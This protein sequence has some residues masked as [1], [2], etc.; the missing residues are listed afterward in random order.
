MPGVARSG[1]WMDCQKTLVDKMFSRGI[2]VSC[3]S[4]PYAV[5][6]SPMCMCHPP[7]YDGTDLWSRLFSQ[8][9]QLVFSWLWLGFPWFPVRPLPV[10]YTLW[11]PACVMHTLSSQKIYSE[12]S[13]ARQCQRLMETGDGLCT[14]VTNEHTGRC[15]FVGWLTRSLLE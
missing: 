11:F 3:R 6:V 1:Y 4:Q 9:F 7:S 8:G 14:L 10:D 5:C 13:G 2:I 12:Q 15:V